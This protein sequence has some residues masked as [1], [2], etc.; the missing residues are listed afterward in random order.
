MTD[1]DDDDRQFSPAERRE[2]RNMLEAQERAEWFWKSA[3]VWAM[4]ISAAI[5]G[6]WAAAEAFEKIVRRIV[7][8]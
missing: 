4:W 3:R 8:L 6:S 1:N 7:S 2:I 5:V